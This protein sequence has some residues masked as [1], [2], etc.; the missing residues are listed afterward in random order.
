MNSKGRVAR[1]RWELVVWSILV[2]LALAGFAYRVW[3]APTMPIPA[4]PAG[5]QTTPV[6]PAVP[7]GLQ[8]T[9]VQPAGAMAGAVTPGVVS[10]QGTLTDASGKPLNGTINMTFRLYA[11]PTGGTAVWTEAHT[12]AN[13]VPVSNG[14]FNVLLGSLTPIP[15]E[16][17]SN[18]TLYLGVQVGSDAEMTPRELVGGVPVAQAAGV[19]QD[20]LVGQNLQMNLHEL[21]YGTVAPGNYTTLLWLYGYPGWDYAE[22]AASYP[23]T[24]S[25][26]LQITVGDNV[27]DRIYIGGNK[28]IPWGEPGGLTVY[29]NGNAHLDGALSSGAFV[30]NNLQTPS[31]LAS[32]RI[33]YFSQGDL[34]CWDIETERLAKCA[35]AA[36]FLVQAVADANGKPIVLG[37]E[38]VKVLGPVAVGDLLVASGVPGYAM[39]WHGTERPPAGA[40]IAQA[41]AAFEGEQ[42]LVKAMIRKF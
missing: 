33:D 30:E 11:A 26:E 8:A 23:V 36:T 17:W 25:M 13:A 14:L 37:A 42:G 28:T 12:G 16:V 21:D 27:D 29:G 6:P 10:Y 7:P 4:T 39:A 41:L 38:P 1:N 18:A 2:L 40:V 24:D 5:L 22:I 19:A 3:A 35:E 32:P 9:T 15:S 31:E 20:L 34:L